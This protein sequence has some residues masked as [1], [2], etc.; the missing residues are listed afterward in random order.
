MFLGLDM[1][2]VVHQPGFWLIYAISRL[3]LSTR[4]VTAPVASGSSLSMSSLEALQVSQKSAQEWASKLEN[5]LLATTH[6]LS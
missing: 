6:C 5:P 1:P 2:L 3:F 4:V